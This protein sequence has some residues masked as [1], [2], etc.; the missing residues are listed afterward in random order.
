M[1]LVIINSDQSCL[2]QKWLK[3]NISSPY[4]KFDNFDLEIINERL[5]CLNI[6]NVQENI[7][8]Y[9]N[10]VVN[11]LTNLKKNQAIL[12]LMKTNEN[13][14]YLV[15]DSIS[16][17]I[18]TKN[19]KIINFETINIKNKLDYLKKICLDLKIQ[20]NQIHL[21][22]LSVKLP[23][24][25]G[26]IYHEVQ[27]LSYLKQPITK[28]AIDQYICDYNQESTYNLFENLV[29]G[30]INELL[31]IFQ[32]LLDQKKDIFY[33]IN[34]LTIQATTAYAIKKCFLKKQNAKTIANN[35]GLNFFVV[36]KLI[37]ILYNLNINKVK[38]IIHNLAFLDIKI[39]RN[40]LNKEL[41]LKLWLI[42]ESRKYGK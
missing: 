14:F 18:D 8:I 25:C 16:T 33:L 4:Q 34:S 5:Y 10:E 21:E 9:D 19:F 30:N 41:F 17:K 2:V 28:E 36:N 22:Y 11:N 37:N 13:H 40:N 1:S 7:V 20:I 15:T 31:N 39:K 29:N 12:E 24:D 6:F 27:K 35:L 23:L 42:N 26:V 32:N 3:E 38:E